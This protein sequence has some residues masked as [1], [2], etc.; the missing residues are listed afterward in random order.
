MNKKDIASFRRQLKVENDLLKISEIF[1]VYIMKESSEIYHQVST[2]FEMLEKEQQ[3]LFMNNFKKVLAGQLDQKLFEMRFAPDAENSSQLILHQAMLSN[4]PEDWNNRM[5]EIVEKM[6]SVKQYEQD[7][8]VT[9][10]RGE[11]LKTVKPISE[12][13]EESD[14]D[15]VYSHSFIMC[16]INTTQDPKKELLFDYVEKEFKYN[17]VVDPIIDLNSPL[18]GFLFPCFSEG[19]ADVNHILYSAGKSKELDFS[20]IEDVLN[21][22]EIMTAEEDKIVF[23]EI[24]KDVAGEQLSTETLANVYEEIQR[25]IEETDP[26]DTPKLDYRDV[27]TVLKSSGVE[28]VETE[29]VEAAFKKVI[30]DEHFE[31]KANNVMPKYNSKSIKVQTKVADLKLSPQELRYVRQMRI[32]GKLCLVI[33]LEENTVIE[34]FEMLT[35]D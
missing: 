9:F 5:L 19:A 14:R 28:D 8:V 4:D 15:K 29:K 1:N 16:T 17:F 6:L 26:E 31:L 7:I 30:D 33:E 27:E 34:G 21:A 35:E 24:V 10:I 23:E 20:F 32:N 13:T 25:V 18:S 3:E 11:Y 22:E 2:P 12:E